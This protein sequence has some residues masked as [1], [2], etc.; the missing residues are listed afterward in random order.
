MPGRRIVFLDR[1]GVINRRLPGRRFVSCWRDFDF[2]PG[3]QEGICLL[4]RAGLTV[5]LV[6]NQ[7]GISMGLYS[8]QQLQEIHMAMCSSLASA[9]ARLDGIYY[10][11]H[12]RGTCSCRK[13]GLGLFQQ[14]FTDFPDA[15]PSASVVVGDSLS[16]MKAAHAIGCYKILINRKCESFRKLVLKHRLVVD[17]QADS[18][19]AAVC[20]YILPTA[21][22]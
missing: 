2:L 14:A 15:A 3:A 8:D 18:L 10:C 4:N 11:P 17:F 16:D 6:T 21:F 12:A 13:P 9:G 5:I 7:R 1:D 20:N 19:L 22:N